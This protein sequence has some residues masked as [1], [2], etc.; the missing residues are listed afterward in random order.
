[1]ETI[2]SPVVVRPAAFDTPVIIALP[3][4]GSHYPDRLRHVSRLSALSLRRSEDA[5]LDEL[6]DFASALGIAT[7]A[8]PFARAYVD[9][10][11][12][13]AERDPQLVG[14]VPLAGLSDRVNAGLGVVPRIVGPGIEIYAGPISATEVQTRVDTVHKPYHATLA[15]LIAQ[16]RARHGVALVLDFHSMPSGKFLGKPLANIVLGD[17]HGQSCDGALTDCLEQH[18]AAQ[19]LSV[20]RNAPYA[21]GYSTAHHG[22]PAAGVHMIQIEL[23]RSL[24]MDEA[25][26]EPHSGFAPLRAQLDQ[27]MR[28]LMADV[29]QLRLLL[30]RDWQQPQAA[31]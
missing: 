27:M 16:T 22:A 26:I 30:A 1:M 17:C 21:G 24:Y 2:F 31:E 18:C 19:H 14:G 28:A 11:R 9:V 20:A 8:T 29:P 13:P 15:T 10:N 3:H 12:S 25:R 6:L 4:S 23:D 5:Y 7:V